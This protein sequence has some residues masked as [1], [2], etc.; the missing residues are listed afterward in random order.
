MIFEVGV[1]TST[2]INL[3]MMSQTPLNS[4]LMDALHVLPLP[5]ELRM[6]VYR[7]SQD[8]WIQEIASLMG[9]LYEIFVKMRYLEAG[10]IE[11]PPHTGSKTLDMKLITKLGL[12]EDLMSLLQQLPN[13]VDT[14]T[15]EHRNEFCMF[16]PCGGTFLDYRDHGELVESRDPLWLQPDEDESWDENVGPYMRSWYTLLNTLHIMTYLLPRTEANT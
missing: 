4:E 8:A 13:V 7:L 5:T 16:F 10:Q 3:G 9:D 11:Y 15:F 2:I 12:T 1:T 6:K 14:N